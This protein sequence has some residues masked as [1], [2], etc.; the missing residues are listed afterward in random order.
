[1]PRVSRHF[2]PGY[3]WHITHRC[4][5]GCSKRSI[6][7]TAALRSRRLMSRRTW[8]F[9]MAETGGV[10]YTSFS[11]PRSALVSACSTTR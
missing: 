2:L 4:P 9:G 5:E 7:S 10:I 8:A 6:R 1:M 11:R 3:V